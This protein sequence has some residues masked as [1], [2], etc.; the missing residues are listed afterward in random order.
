MVPKQWQ[1]RLN[2]Y[3]RDYFILQKCNSFVFIFS[4]TSHNNIVNRQFIKMV[5]LLILVSPMDRN[6]KY[7]TAS[8]IFRN[9]AKPQEMLFGGHIWKSSFPCVMPGMHRF[10]VPLNKKGDLLESANQGIPG[11]S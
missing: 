1:L 7:H 11:I 3:F 9:I 8:E 10:C 2:I 5:H 6:P 4:V